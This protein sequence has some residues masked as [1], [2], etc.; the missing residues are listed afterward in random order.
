[1]D[2]DLVI[3]VLLITGL[4]F[5]VLEAFAPAFG[6]LGVLG[7][8]SFVCALVLLDD[9][10]DFY[11]MTVNV[12]L[13][14]GVG[15]V[16]LVILVVSVYATYRV[17]R[18]RITAGAETMINR[19]ARVVEWNEDKGRVFVD[20]EIWQATG[21]QGLV[22]GDSVTIISRDHLTLKIKKDV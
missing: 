12:P 15:L 7:V 17:R 10:A 1:M 20:G 13:M 2:G 11:G 22:I 9:Q 8:I 18:T 5:M 19:I 14:V 16:G 4:A 21:E 3:L 6:L